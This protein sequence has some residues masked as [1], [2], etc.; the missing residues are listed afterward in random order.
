MNYNKKSIEDVHLTFKEKQLLKI[1]KKKVKG[2][3]I[4]I[5]LKESGLFK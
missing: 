4:E 1:V 2:T 5:L 3:D